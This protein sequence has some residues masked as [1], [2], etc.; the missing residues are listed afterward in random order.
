MA[1]T[2][3]FGTHEIQRPDASDA[4]STA[5]GP[6][7]PFRLSRWLRVLRMS[8]VSRK[9]LLLTLAA[10]TILGG[11]GAVEPLLLK[12]F[13]DELG[14]SRVNQLGPLLLLL[15]LFVTVGILREATNAVSNGLTWRTRIEFQQQLLDATVGRL[16]TLPLSYHRSH[17]VGG[18]M[19][20]LDR[21]IQGVVTGLSEL[22]FSA[23]P[24]AIFVILAAVVMLRL[25]PLGTL[26]VFAFMPVPTI[27]TALTVKEQ[28]VR[29]KDLMQRWSSIYARF[30]EVLSGILT[31]K[32]FVMEEHEKSRF[33]KGVREANGRVVRGVWRDAWI[34]SGKNTAVTLARAVALGW[35]G[36]WALRGHGS[37]GT[38]VA[39]LTFVN[40]L[41]TPFQSL[42][43]TYSVVQKTSAALDV[44]FS[45]LDAQDSLGDAPDAKELPRLR[46]DVRY[47]NVCFS[48][49]RKRTV[50]AGIDLDIKAGQLVAIVGPSGSGKTT[51]MG[52]LQRLYDPTCGQILVDGHD[53]RSLKQRSLRRHIG[54][55]LQDGLLFNDTVRMNIAYG[56]PEST[57]REIVAAAKAAH[58]HEFIREMPQG[59]DTPI[60]VRGSRLSGGQ[61]QRLGIARALLKDPP[62]LILDEATSALDAESEA[63]IQDALDHLVKNR[64]AFVIAHRLSTV[65][66][67][68]HII[69]LK[70]GHIVE[71]GRHA[72]LMEDGGY[73]A[74]LVHRQIRDLRDQA[75]WPGET[76]RDLASPYRDH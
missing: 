56:C 54:V 69:V 52:L 44:V 41:F 16:H 31:V 47:N 15:G 6:R 50:L 71:Q 18:I 60:G 75:Q 42:L 9:R 4:S 7:T 40:A 57:D 2:T 10:T 23:L 48:F 37:V 53:L 25:D 13:L 33:L 43:G 49:D 20:R 12:E 45:I 73:Y 58:A 11:L 24:S 70:A 38:V 34:G 72:A 17:D 5:S 63:I 3:R 59:Y 46:G 51:M 68:D 14:H 1:S 67:A 39:F 22:T 32:S 66:H 27:V 28:A 26:L 36:Y 65:V 64:T 21:G 8:G 35:G 29:E 30:N 62:I 74:S 19:T 55:V 61:R 76:F